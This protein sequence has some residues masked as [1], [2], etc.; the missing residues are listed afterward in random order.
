[1]IAAIVERHVTHH[2]RAADT[3][4]GIRSWWVAPYRS[5]DSLADVQRALDYLVDRGR[6]SRTVL[7]DGT[8]IYGGAASPTNRE[9]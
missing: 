8:L 1:M 2:P 9:A 6:M 4:E 7:P 5:G 3:S